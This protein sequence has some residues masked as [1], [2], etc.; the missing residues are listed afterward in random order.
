MQK[1]VAILIVVS[2]ILTEAHSVVTRLFPEL[3]EQDARHLFFKPVPFAVPFKW[4]IKFNTDA[5][6]LTTLTGCL[7]RVTVQVS[8]RLFY[9]SVILFLYTGFD[10]G[11]FIYNYKLSYDAYWSVIAAIVLM[12]FS[13]FLPGKPKAKIIQMQ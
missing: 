3:A 6:L 2:L 12:I 5:I 13:M 8:R 10:Y 7:A 11:M 9:I 1:S 4:W